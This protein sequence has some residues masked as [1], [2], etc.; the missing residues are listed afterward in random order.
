[1]LSGS[2]LQAMAVWESVDTAG[3]VPLGLSEGPSPTFFSQ[4]QTQT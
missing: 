4:L 2:D 1:M 3:E